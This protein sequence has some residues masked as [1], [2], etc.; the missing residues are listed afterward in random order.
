MYKSPNKAKV[1]Y[2]ADK[3][4][5]P[6]FFTNDLL[7]VVNDL[8]DTLDKD[9]HIQV[10]ADAMVKPNGLPTGTLIS[11]NA[12]N[13]MLFPLL[14]RDPG[15][16]YLIFKMKFIEKTNSDWHSIAGQLL[17]ELVNKK[18]T[19]SQASSQSLKM[20][21]VI[22]RGIHTIDLEISDI[23]RFADLPLPVDTTLVNPT[24][25]ELDF[26]SKGFKEL[27]NTIEIRKV[28]ESNHNQD[29]AKFD[30]EK[31]DMI[32]FIHT[33]SH[34]FPQ[35]LA[36]R[37]VYRIIEYADQNHLFPVDQMKK[38][39]FGVPLNTNLGREYAHWLQAAMNYVV[40]SRYLLYQDVKKQLEANF[41]CR[42]T[43]LKDSIHAGLFI[44][45]TNDKT[46][47]YCTRG[48]QKMSE[49]NLVAG[50]RE[51]VAALVIPG[52]KAQD[53]DNLLA[54]GTS[55]HIQANHDYAENFNDKDSN[56]YQDLAKNAFYNSQ[57]KYEECL[58]YTY[59]LLA[60]LKYMER[61]GLTKATTLL[62]PLINI[63]SEWLKH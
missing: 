48:V 44:N 54:H 62:T 55:Y 17:D 15:C 49:L 63:Q 19:T 14:L 28:T 45:T 11:A 36:E 1:T 18:L 39:I 40:T 30:L 3:E 42:L 9:T 27:T 12:D 6:F 47:V 60:S 16:G 29:L 22:E 56:K 21:N 7:N 25:E 20:S 10:F 13:A 37:F 52:E 35:L 38:G 41:P 34:A 23:N 59:N 32:G 61:I 50:Q 5:F 57:P 24:R 26:L 58:P 53:F 51:T 46:I 8:S 2:F 33:G 4:Q 43:L 31:E